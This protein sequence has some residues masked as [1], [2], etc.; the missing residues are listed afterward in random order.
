[1]ASDK[2]LKNQQEITRLKKLQA[3]YDK[4]SSGF[5]KADVANSDDFSSLLRDNLK[6]LKLVAAAKSEILSIDRRITKQVNDAFAFDRKQ[7]GTTKANSELEKQRLQLNRDILIL[8]QKKGSQLTS[9]KKLQSQINVTLK[10]RKKD[11][12]ELLKVNAKN[13][14]F[15]KKVADNMSVRAFS[16]LEG[17]ASKIGLGDFAQELGDAAK[18]SREAAA[19]NIE[20]KEAREELGIKKSALSNL[21]DEEKGIIEKATA[22]NAGEDGFGGGLTKKLMKKAGLE[23]MGT[24]VGAAAKI[25]GAGGIKGIS[26]ATKSLSPLLKG[27]KA[28]APALKKILGPLAILA[29]VLALDKQTAD[30]AKGMN[31]TYKEAQGLRKEMTQIALD[32]ENNF[33]TGKKVAETF[34]FLNNTLG[35]TGTKMDSELLTTM[36]ALREMAGMTN[37]E[38]MG[39]AMISSTTGE[40]MED[41]TGEFMA[42]AK[43]AGLQNGVMVNTKTLSKDLSKLSA[44]TTLSLGKN[45][46]LLGEALAVTKALGM[47]MAQLEGIAS[48]LMNFEDSIK[49]ELE[50]ELLLGKNINLEKARQA[51]LNNDLATLA[52]E[53]AEQAGTAA[54]FGEMNRIQQEALAKAVGM[55]R[56]ELAQT[57]YVQE[58]LAGATGEEAAEQEA[59]LNA[60]IAEVGL[61]Q[62]QKEMAKDGFEGLKNQAGMADRMGAAMDKLNEVFVTIVEAAMPF[63][64]VLVSIFDI[65]GKITKFIDP[66]V[67]TVM[68]GVAAIQD[69]VSG[70]GWIFGDKDA[71]DGGSAIKNQI[72]AAEASAQENWGFSGDAF[73]EQGQGRGIYDRS[74][75][76]RTGGTITGPESGYPVTLHGA[77]TVVPLDPKGIKVDNRKMENTLESISKH[78]AGLNNGP[79]FAINRG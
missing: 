20:N 4:R 73:N 36:T 41:V 48:G 42:S 67:Q 74:P 78:L 38:L 49:N 32:S 10:Q 11:A 47:E 66:M 79:V 45:P 70:I 28:L 24:G 56:D 55:S 7:L 54:E 22:G 23:N 76:M 34:S 61:A 31:M 35:V 13:A 17:I 19:E 3:E 12:E 25:K 8:E 2:E 5:S 71:F 16:G 65:I 51:A 63:L 33:V 77:E 69:L 44:A 21:T 39:L 1:M 26:K 37:E 46:A 14:D 75:K 50:A 43:A 59:I 29:E 6:N 64:D 60:R 9:D 53:I 40:D 57:L 15:S 30:M 72:Q 58:Q 62:A 27:L 18:A 68:V 52:S